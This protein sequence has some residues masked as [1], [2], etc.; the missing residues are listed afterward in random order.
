[1][2]NLEARFEVQISLASNEIINNLKTLIQARPWG[3][4]S[5]ALLRASSKRLN[6]QQK[7]FLLK[8]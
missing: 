2:K 8:R 4:N 1:M 7:R 6:K 5:H 3:Q